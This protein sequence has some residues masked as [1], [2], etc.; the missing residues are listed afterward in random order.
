MKK[1]P[2]LTI[3]LSLIFVQNAYSQQCLKGDCKN[4]VGTMTWTS[5]DKY[6]GQFKNGNM[7]GK[8]VMTYKSGIIY[9]GLWLK[10]N[11]KGNGTMTWPNGDRYEGTFLNNKMS[12]YGTM[13]YANGTKYTGMWTNGLIDKMGTM[14]WK[15]GDKYEGIFKNGKRDGK[16]TMTWKSGDKY[17]GQWKNDQMD[18]EGTMTY[19]GKKAVKGKWKNGKLIEEAKS[20]SDVPEPNGSYGL[21]CLLNPG[22]SRYAENPRWIFDFATGGKGTYKN[23][24]GETQLTGKISWKLDGKVLTLTLIGMEGGPQKYTYDASKKWFAENPRPYGP[25]NKVMTVCIIKKR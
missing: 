12:T 13:T 24:G 7:E 3:L 21:F 20:A 1:I 11:M 8:G 19:A 9:K 16:G 14:T 18:G 17:N 2:A 25:S 22:D 5:G 6:E 23:F 4:G 15:N 10:G